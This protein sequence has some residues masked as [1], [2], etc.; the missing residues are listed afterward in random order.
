MCPMQENHSL[1]ERIT[2]IFSLVPLVLYIMVA[3]MLSVIAIISLYDSA[4]LVYELIRN[5][6]SI[7]TSE[8]IIG[9]INAL[10]LTITIIVLFETVTVYFRTRHVEVRTL[11]I[12]GLTGVVRHVLVYNVA[13]SDIYQ[14]FAAVAVLAVLIAGIVLIKPEPVG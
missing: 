4:N 14:L 2:G 7:T 6:R 8:Q 11:L 12:A 3:I 5:I 1:M 13:S 9:V 10:L